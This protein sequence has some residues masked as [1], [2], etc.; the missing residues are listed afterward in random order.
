MIHPRMWFRRA[1]AHTALLLACIPATALADAVPPV[2]LLPFSWDHVPYFVH[3]S[4]SSGPVSPA[5]LDLQANAGFTVIQ[6][7]QGMDEPGGICPDEH[8]PVSCNATGAEAKCAA[9]AARIKAKSPAARVLLYYTCDNVRVESDFGRSLIKSHPELLLEQLDHQTGKVK[10]YLYDWSQ[11]ATAEVWAKGIAAAVALGNFSGVFI[12]GYDG[13]HECF[14]PVTPPAPPSLSGTPSGPPWRQDNPSGSGLQHKSGCPIHG[15]PMTPRGLVNQT[16]FLTNKNYR[17]GIALRAALPASSVMIPNCEGGY[18]CRDGKGASRL[19]GFNAVMEE[20][21]GL[22]DQLPN[23]TDGTNGKEPGDDESISSLA[24]IAHRGTLAEINWTDERDQ[25]NSILALAAYL[26][27]AGENQFFG[28][29]GWY[30]NCHEIPVSSL[31]PLYAKPLGPPLTD[32]V[33]TVT[34]LVGPSSPAMIVSERRF[35]HGVRVML[36]SSHNLKEGWARCC[37]RW[38]DGSNSSC[39]PGDCTDVI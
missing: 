18:G 7:Q 19:P 31:A 35:T 10:G 29:I 12:D 2:P 13:W 38:G 28:A 33:R 27:G 23:A 34:P 1:A 22:I 21:F 9:A 8:D 25:D 16:A 17:S 36:N 26:I 5:I 37:I 24:K 6:I 11:P 15:V 4:N 14:P 20:F 30:W 3:C 32:A 39:A